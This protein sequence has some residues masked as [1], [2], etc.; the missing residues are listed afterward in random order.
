MGEVWYR[1]VKP[2]Y[3]NISFGKACRWGLCRNFSA[4]LLVR[5]QSHAVYTQAY[6]GLQRCVDTEI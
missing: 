6:T 4:D 1:G 2:M 3:C 5:P